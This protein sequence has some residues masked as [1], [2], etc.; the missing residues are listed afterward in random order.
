M[1]TLSGHSG[2]V[3]AL[4]YSPD[5]RLLVSGGFDRTVRLWDLQTRRESAV[6]RDCLNTVVGV[7]FS[8]DG[9]SLAVIAEDSPIRRWD[10]TTRRECVRLPR[11]MN[12]RSAAFLADGRQLAT[13]SGLITCVAVDPSGTTVAVGCGYPTGWGR[14]M[15][16]VWDLAT[17]SQTI[18]LEVSDMGHWQAHHSAITGQARTVA[19]GGGLRVVKLWQPA[20]DQRLPA[21]P[22]RQPLRAVTFSPDGVTLASAAG[23]K[24]RLWDV[25]TGGERSGLM[26]HA[27]MVE[28]LAF[29]ADGATLLSGS[30]DRSV[31]LWDVA[32][33]RPRGSYRWP[34]GK[35]HAVAVSPDGLTAAAA[36]DAPDIVVWDLDSA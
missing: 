30:A 22:H 21:L 32:S 25:A 2:P 35:V 33:G 3:T 28:A 6:F 13:G 16:R 10:M 24:I 34:L 20:S 19:M 4:A 27:N 29:T 12:L 26:G 36:G 5:G 9:G 17:G 31:R 8:P 18:T 23:N 14:G 11:Q 1:L 15:V 7:A